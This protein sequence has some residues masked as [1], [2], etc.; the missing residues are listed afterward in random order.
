MGSKVRAISVFHYHLRP[1]GVTSVIA[2]ACEAWAAYLPE[3]ELIRL[4]SGSD[5]HEEE[6]A[7]KIRERIGK[8]T[9]RIET[10]VLPEIGYVSGMP[11]PPSVESIK[12][13][14]RQFSGSL[15]W[16]HNYHIGKNPQFTQALLEILNEDPD[17]EILFHIHDFPECARYENLQTLREGIS[18]DPYPRARNLRYALINDRDRRLMA[19]SGLPEEDLFLLNNPVRGG[20][21][22][23]GAGRETTRKKLAFAFGR[24]PGYIPEGRHLFY[25]VRTIR[26]KNI[27]EAGFLTRLLAEETGEEVNL[28][29][30]LPGVSA[31]EK[32]YSRCVA[33]AF[34]RGLIPGLWG[35]GTELDQAGI[36]FPDLGQACDMVVASSV[37]EGFGYLFIE[38]LQWELPLFARDLE[39][40]DGIR[41]RFSRRYSRFYR[42]L[43]VPAD[44]RLAARIRDS[45]RKKLSRLAEHLP[46]ASLARLDGEIGDIGREGCIDFALLSVEDQ[47][48]V[49]AR[50]NETDYRRQCLELNRGEISTC[51]ALFG[52]KPKREE[53]EAAEEEFSFGR[54]AAKSREII[55]SY[56]DD[57]PHLVG[58]SDS[59]QALLD[60]FARLEYML[61]LYDYN[62]DEA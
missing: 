40:L 12:S 28:I 54:F 37:Q 25:P 32:R 58:G 35:I 4:V 21:P 22:A 56:N 43:T 45:Y 30:T 52:E 36:A 48:A 19:T 57:T 38:A 34:D 60:A 50:L 20:R 47:L 5:E 23:K 14:L 18:L 29:V 26:R 7:G 1:G 17:Q 39:I 59:Q 46:P 16:I 2:L 33:D 53:I 24:R 3:I 8:Q 27:L 13:H 42:K 62:G 44:D 61:L 9:T 15:W 31:T 41:P 49:L 10:A 55:A 11:S 6:L 51:S